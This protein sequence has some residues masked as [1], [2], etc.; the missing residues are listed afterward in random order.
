MQDL[1]AIQQSVSDNFPSFFKA[2]VCHLWINNISTGIMYAI[3][4]DQ[5]RI[6]CIPAKGVFNDVLS[7]K[8]LVNVKNQVVDRGY[9][10][11]GMNE[12][13]DSSSLLAS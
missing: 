3:S 13:D 9:L 12:S 6:V 8:Q 11:V 4:K 7:N 2:R 5:K 10:Y 1:S